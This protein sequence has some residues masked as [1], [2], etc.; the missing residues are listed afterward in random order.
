MSKPILVVKNLSIY[1]LKKGKEISLIENVSFNINEHETLSFVGQ[2]GS[3][4]TITSLSLL[5][6]FDSKNIFIKNGTIIFK[7]KEIDYKNNQQRKLLGKNISMIFQDPIT[8]LNPVY[9]I[10]RQIAEMFIFHEAATKEEAKRKS[11]E[12]LEEVKIA[13]SEIVF[14]QYPHELSGGMRQ[15]IMIAIAISCRVKLLIADEPTTA[16]D[17]TIQKEILDLL[18]DLKKKNQISILFIT[19]DF[20]LVAHYADR[21]AVFYQG[22]MI[23]I[24]E[25]KNILKNPKN[26]YTKK[27]VDAVLDVKKKYA[28]KKSSTKD[29][30]ILSIKNLK[31]YYPIY[32]GFL[33]RKVSENKAVDDVSFFIRKGQVMGMVGESGCGKSSIAKALV[34]ISETTGG[35]ISISGENYIDYNFKQMKKIRRKIQLIFQ[36]AHSSMNPNLRI[37]EILKEPFII[38]KIKMTK[39]EMHDK[40]ISLLESVDLQESDLKK[41]TNE[42]S[43]GQKQRVV[44]ARALATDPKVIIADESVASLDVIVRKQILDLLK[45][46][47]QERDLTILFISHDLGVIKYIA[48]KISVIYKGKIVEEGDTEE[49]LKNPKDDYTKK[50]LASNLAVG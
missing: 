26:D 1:V 49:V 40:L 27:L 28:L 8:S 42:L 20:S 30:E 32:K 12:L 48:E 38:H 5:G 25:V 29:K 45:K 18:N 41:Y 7:G 9:T 23:D 14:D 24:G 37:E 17:V 10:G 31:I 2:S 16:L 47:Q 11:I 4:K 34:G 44:I 22:K 43:G 33:K 35:E 50:L 3:G 36:D 15:R 6:L 19:H 46:I 21:V 39:K 13:N